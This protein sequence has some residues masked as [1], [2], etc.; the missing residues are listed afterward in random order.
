MTRR[1]PS[2]NACPPVKPAG[3]V[4]LEQPNRVRSGEG[5]YDRGMSHQ[6]NS[7]SQRDRGRSMHEQY[8]KEKK[9]R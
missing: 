1:L 2:R 7:V 9:G 8:G 6:T 3:R 4:V 5:S